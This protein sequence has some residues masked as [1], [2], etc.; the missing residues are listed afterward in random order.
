MI[1]F[2]FCFIW[3]CMFLKKKKMEKHRKG[4][5]KNVI[6]IG[7]FILIC[8]MIFVFMILLKNTAFDICWQTAFST[9]NTL[10]QAAVLTIIVACTKL[11]LVILKPS[12]RNISSVLHALWCLHQLQIVDYPVVKWL[13]FL[14]E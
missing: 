6:S 12:W 4:F 11:F 8:F 1:I 10:Y 9:I 5:G 14:K 13:T 7:H 2:H 3:V